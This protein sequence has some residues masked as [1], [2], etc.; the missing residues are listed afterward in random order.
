[1]WWDI[2]ICLFLTERLKDTSLNKSKAKRS[3]ER[4]KEKNST[5]I[6]SFHTHAHTQNKKI[7]THK[8]SFHP[9]LLCGTKE[10]LPMAM[11]T[12]MPPFHLR[13]ALHVSL[14]HLYQVRGCNPP[15]PVPSHPIPSHPI[16]SRPE[17]D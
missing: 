9:L 6:L 3:N 11:P 8:K 17:T 13:W 14:R 2:I 12:L 16:P 15:H 4:N 10:P 5:T 7:G 1:L